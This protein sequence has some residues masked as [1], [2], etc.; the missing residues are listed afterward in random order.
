MYTTDINS[1]VPIKFYRV[2]WTDVGWMEPYLL[3]EGFVLKNP[4][5]FFQKP[6]MVVDNNLSTP[7][8]KIFSG[9]D[10]QA[11]RKKLSFFPDTIVVLAA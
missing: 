3:K 6:H 2:I 7:F 4:T 11:Q 10:D 9:K 8:L 1:S 5:F